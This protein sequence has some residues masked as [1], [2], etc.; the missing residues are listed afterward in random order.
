MEEAKDVEV[1]GAGGVD[2]V[3]EILG[4]EGEALGLVTG[5]DIRAEDGL[6]HGADV[7]FG[8][9]AEEDAAGFERIVGLR[10]AEDVV[11]RLRLEAEQGSQ[12][13]ISDLRPGWLTGFGGRA[14]ARVLFCR[15]GL[16]A[17]VVRL[18][19]PPGAGL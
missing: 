11:P 14:G 6:G 5:S 17:G 15:K 2:G 3:E 13:I 18:V 7:A 9:G 10:V 16:G 19:I 12:A 8:D 4:I 1:E